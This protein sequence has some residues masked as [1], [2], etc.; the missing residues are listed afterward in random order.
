MGLYECSVCGYVY[1]EASE[2][3]LWN[4]LNEDWVCPVCESGKVYFEVSETTNTPEDG[5]SN[6]SGETPSS[7][8]RT[9]KI[10]Y[11]ATLD[12]PKEFYR[13]TDDIEPYMN[14]IHQMAITG[15]TV[16]EPMR[17]K[18][19][20]VSWEDILIRGAQ[21]DP[22]V[23]PEDTPISGQTVIGKHAKKPLIIENPVFVTHMSFGALSK[24]MKFALASGSAG[25]KTAMCSGEG[26]ILE[27]SLNRSYRYIFEY[28]PNLYS[29]TDENL[30]KVD[31]IEIKMGQGTKPGLG[32]H[33]PGKKVTEEI[34]KVRQ[35]PMNQDIISPSKF[36]GVDTKEDLKALVDN[37]RERSGGRPIGIKIAAGHIKK[38]LAVIAYAG[39]DF[40]TIDGRTGG[41]GASPKVIKDTTTLPTIFALYRAKEYMRENN[42]DID[43]IITG[44][45]RLSSQF[46]KALAIGADAIAIGTAAM[47]ATACQQYR[48]CDTGKCPVGVATQDPILRER[49]H[50]EHSAKRLENF[51]NASLD[52]IK[53]FARICGHKDVHD[54]CLEDLCT[55]NSEISGH[56]N[57]EHV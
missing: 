20:A 1:D 44:G 17:S 38:D 24:E 46:A 19:P 34:A 28:V 31:A 12:Y 50:V 39:A 49:L 7:D 54:L 56:T 42:L 41:T 3:I 23:L 51:L 33:L 10:D 43:L 8:D 47:M 55:L 52:E 6:D 57:I 40:I 25:A 29:V 11:E 18:I 35:K 14:M 32:G 4:D 15:K 9:K 27:E 48:I 53:A 16:I 30:K 2:G 21:L 36:E 37:L 5:A 22:F 26:G 13:A 45:L